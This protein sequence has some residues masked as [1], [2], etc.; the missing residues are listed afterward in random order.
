MTNAAKLDI[1]EPII[2][3]GSTSRSSKGYFFTKRNII[4][5][6]V[7]FL[8]ILILVALLAAYFGPGR[9]SSEKGDD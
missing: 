8:I 4:L 9:G 3:D 5:C 1:E 2:S 6:L 7:V